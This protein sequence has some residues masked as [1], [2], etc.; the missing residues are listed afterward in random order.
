[1]NPEQKKT[2]SQHFTWYLKTMV[3]N[4]CKNLPNMSETQRRLQRSMDGFLKKKQ[5]LFCGK[6]R[7][8][9]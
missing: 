3:Q 9:I 2:I 4:V 8:W 6:N 5:K 7:V 1:M